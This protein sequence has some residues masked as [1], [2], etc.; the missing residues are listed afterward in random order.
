MRLGKVVTTGPRR[1]ETGHAREP[2]TGN[3]RRRG[4]EV[5]VSRER[6]LRPAERQSG[7]RNMLSRD[8]ESAISTGTLFVACAGRSVLL[9]RVF[10][11]TSWRRVR[12]R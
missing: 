1:A 4:N 7:G 11:G 8:C 5:A 12:D 9:P 10:Y 3:S 2:E 6:G